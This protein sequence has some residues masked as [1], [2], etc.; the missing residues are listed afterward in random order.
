MKLGALHPITGRQWEVTDERDNAIWP[1]CVIVVPFSARVKDATGKVVNDAA[2]TADQGGWTV[3][4][5]LTELELHDLVEDNLVSG[6]TAVWTNA[7]DGSDTPAL[8]VLGED[9][10]AWLSPHL[11]VPASTSVSTPPWLE[12]GFGAGPPTTS[13]VPMRFGELV[14]EPDPELALLQPPIPWIVN[15]A[16]NA[17]G[18]RLRFGWAS[19]APLIV[20]G[21]R[22]GVLSAERMGIE[23]IGGGWKVVDHMALP[24]SYSLTVVEADLG[25]GTTSEVVNPWPGLVAFVRY[26]HAATTHHTPERITLKPGHYELRIKGHTNGDAPSGSGMQACEQ[27]DWSL[28]GRFW[29]DHPPSLRP[30]V[31]TSTVGDDRLFG[32]SAGFDPTLPGVGFPAH[33]GYRTAVR[34]RVPYVREMFPSLW[35]SGDYDDGHSIGE[36]TPIGSDPDGKSSLPEASQAYKLAH[37]G[38]VAPDDEVSPG[39]TLDQ[40]PAG[41]HLRHRLPDGA[42]VDLDTWAVIVSRFTGAGDHLAWDGTCVTRC[43]GPTGPVEQAA[44][45]TI[46]STGFAKLVQGHKLGRM[47]DVTE[48]LDLISLAD[49][50]A[51]VSGGLAGKLLDQTGPII[52]GKLPD[53][54]TAAPADWVLETALAELTG[55][56]GEDAAQRFLLFLRRSGARLVAGAG[57]A[58]QDVAEPVAQTVV[59]AVT[60]SDGRPLALWL[61]TPEPL[62]WRRAA[63]TAS[64]RHVEPAEG[65]PTGYARR[66]RLE[67]AVRVVPSVDGSQAL[68][69]LE[70]AG[71]PIRVPRGEVTLTLRYDSRAANLVPLRPRAALQGGVETVALTFLQPFGLSWPQPPSGG[72]GLGRFPF[73]DDVVVGPKPLWPWDIWGPF[74]PGSVVN[75]G[76]VIRRRGGHR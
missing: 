51:V 71:Q 36:D 26:R 40:G 24:G 63:A 27:V 1:D 31:A 54:L 35:V 76:D 38:T 14:V 46:A 28:T 12:Q 61:R 2:G 15:R 34:F 65:C 33:R 41:L 17:P 25:G 48:G 69:V 23:Q 67:A 21:V 49:V 52:G 20:D 62:D 73:P 4:S 32:R 9:P 64:I 74:D 55:A 44:C 37:G 29:V 66:R 45:P 11:D 53:E 10:F 43:F 70:F 58:L 22:L 47:H 56:L 7:P 16:L 72:G 3:T 30:Y 50:T 18:A 57:P 75:P 6:V 19:D 8:H 68:L 60:D 39:A 5:E 42:R 13:M 59:D